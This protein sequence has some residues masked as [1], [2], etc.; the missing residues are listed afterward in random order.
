MQI[1]RTQGFNSQQ[2]STNLNVNGHGNT[3]NLAN[4][5]SNSHS[6]AMTDSMAACP[7]E[8]PPSEQFG[9]LLDGLMNSFGEDGAHAHPHAPAQPADGGNEG[10]RARGRG[11]RRGK[12]VA[13]GGRGNDRISQKGARRQ[14]AKGGRGN[15]RIVQKG[16]KRQVAKG[17]AGN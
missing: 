1:N 9:V 6:P 14:V 3:I 5:N 8:Q 11:G 15:D 10:G 17:G 13:K 2:I 12:Q 7:H 4:L 16:G